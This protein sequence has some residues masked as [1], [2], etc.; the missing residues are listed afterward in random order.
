MCVSF[1]VFMCMCVHK[2][3]NEVTRLRDCVV[4]WSKWSV[5]VLTDVGQ[6]S[7]IRIGVTHAHA[8]AHTHTRTNW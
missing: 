6:N 4:V 2:A 7:Y 3:R 8:H 1:S 5:S